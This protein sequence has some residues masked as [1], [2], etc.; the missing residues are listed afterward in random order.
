VGDGSLLYS[1][2]DVASSN[3]IVDSQATEESLYGARLIAGSSSSCSTILFSMLS[4]ALSVGDGDG[5]G[6]STR[7]M[8]AVSILYLEASM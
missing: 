6:R 8:A 3:I 7:T 1:V 5:D 2:F 4:S